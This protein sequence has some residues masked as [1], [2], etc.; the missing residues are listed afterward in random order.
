MAG[1]LG[2]GCD[3]SFMAGGG[4]MG[5][6]MRAHDWSRRRSGRPTA[7]RTAAAVDTLDA[8]H[9]APDVRVVGPDSFAFTT[10][11]TGIDRSRAAPRLAR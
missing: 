11:R 5:A 9:W 10:T 3:P 2:R 6:L 7:G 8:Q 1:V 4:E